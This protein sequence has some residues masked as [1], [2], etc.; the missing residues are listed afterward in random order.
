MPF[1][2]LALA[3]LIEGRADQ[4]WAKALLRPWTLTAW[5]CLTIGIGL[6]SYWAYYELG[7]GGWWFWDR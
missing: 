2:A 3:A 5:T 1:S 4:A 7:W 6:G